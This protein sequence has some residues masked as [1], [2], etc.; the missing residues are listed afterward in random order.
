MSVYLTPTTTDDTNQRIIN[1]NEFNKV[2]CVK[3][4]LKRKAKSA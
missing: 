4:A 1:R 3:Y 2:V